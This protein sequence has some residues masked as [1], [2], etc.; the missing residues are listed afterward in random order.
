MNPVLREL[1]AAPRK[2]T[3]AVALCLELDAAQMTQPEELLRQKG[4]IEAAI[5]ETQRDISTLE[6]V[7]IDLR[8]SAAAPSGV[9]PAGF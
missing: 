8:E 4:R 1:L 2:L 5:T 6:R 9:V 3:A 7:L